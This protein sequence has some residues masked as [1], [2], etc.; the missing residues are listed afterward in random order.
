MCCESQG[1]SLFTPHLLGEQNVYWRVI[2]NRAVFFDNRTGKQKV[3]QKRISGA[4][5]L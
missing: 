3:K 5:F 4:S 2:E 1:E